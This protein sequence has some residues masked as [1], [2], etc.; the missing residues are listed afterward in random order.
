MAPASGLLGS[1]KLEE[2]QV[3]GWLSFLW[4][5]V[6]LPLHVLVAANGS[7]KVSCHMR[8]QLRGALDKVE[9]H[10]KLQDW[11]YLVGQSTTIA[12]IGLAVALKYNSH[13]LKEVLGPDSCLGTWVEKILEE[14]HLSAME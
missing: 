11:G 12:D 3:E 2:A 7:Q 14:C 6:E 8:S 5:F 1:T 9:S 13:M 10:L 4:H